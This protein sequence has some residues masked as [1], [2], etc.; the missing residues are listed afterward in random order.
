MDGD[1]IIQYEIPKIVAGIYTVV[2]RAETLDENNALIE[3][4]IDGKKIGGLLDLSSGGNA[5]YPFRS[6]EL[7]TINLLQYEEHTIEIRSLIPGKFSWDMI[8]FEPYVEN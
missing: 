1:F 7:G 5:N 6:L 3:V 4:F 8:R 2:L